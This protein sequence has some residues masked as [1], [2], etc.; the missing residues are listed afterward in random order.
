ML[1]LGA[2]GV[3]SWNYVVVQ[4]DAASNF[5]GSN[6]QLPEWAR[7][8]YNPGHF[9]SIV[10]HASS[11][12]SDTA[13][14]LNAARQAWNSAY[15]Y[16]TDLPAAGNDHYYSAAPASAVWAQQAAQ[17][18]MADFVYGATDDVLTTSC[19]DASTAT[20]VYP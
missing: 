9:I 17:G 2:G 15:A 13:A 19:P 4:E 5:M 14:L 20:P 11:D 12:A 10:H 1:R 18:G 7:Y 3:D 16:V 6:G 8:Q